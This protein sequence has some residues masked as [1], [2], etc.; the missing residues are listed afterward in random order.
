MTEYTVVFTPEAEGQLAELYRYI[1]DK[2]SANSALRYTNAI[3][4]FCA[5]MKTFPRRGVARDDIRPGLRISNYKKNAIVAFAV[6]DVEFIVTIIGV[7]YGG[8]N[9]ADIIAIPDKP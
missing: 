3:V 7:F 5:A 8:R 9:Y 4:D 6:D 1:A 2:A